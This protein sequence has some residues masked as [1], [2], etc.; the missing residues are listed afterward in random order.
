MFA[1]QDQLEFAK[2]KGSPVLVSVFYEALCPDS[3]GFMVNQLVPAYRKIP[4]LIE[5]EFFPYGKAKTQTL[6]DGKCTDK[7]TR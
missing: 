3:K 5:I 4:N 7:R 6:P 1:F 2:A